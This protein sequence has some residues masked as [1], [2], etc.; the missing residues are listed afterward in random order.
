[1]YLQ[2][3]QRAACEAGERAVPWAHGLVS[4]R[5]WRALC[6][7]PV[8]GGWSTG[9]REL[10][11]GFA[12]VPGRG[13]PYPQL[14]CPGRKQPYSFPRRALS[15]RPCPGSSSPQPG[16]KGESG[17]GA[18]HLQDTAWPLEQF[19]WPQPSQIVA[20]GHAQW[21]KPGRGKSHRAPPSLG[22]G[23]AQPAWQAPA[24]KLPSPPLGC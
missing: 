9:D 8:T 3:R 11:P 24:S 17:A 19:S 18:F 1:M 15:S 12:S 23:R 2:P 21:D 7:P 10:P 4:L 5:R 22:A 13:G 14:R 20:L 16:W 6:L